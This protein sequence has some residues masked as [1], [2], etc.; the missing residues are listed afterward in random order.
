MEREVYWDGENWIDPQDPIE[1]EVEP[2][3]PN[4][5]QVGNTENKI[6]TR[7]QNDFW[8]GEFEQIN[9]PVDFSGQQIDGT[10]NHTPW[11]YY[12]IILIVTAL[13]VTVSP[14]LVLAMVAIVASVVLY[15]LVT[16]YK[17]RRGH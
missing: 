8:V 6:V 1:I 16:A 15:D 9:F 10:E 13:L 4:D 11:A 2:E 17:N 14:W 12:S 3:N 5:F 7:N